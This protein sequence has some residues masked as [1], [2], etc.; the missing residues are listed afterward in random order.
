MRTYPVVPRSALFLCL[1]VLVAIPLVDARAQTA[2]YTPYEGQPGKDV[3]WLPTQQTLVDIMLD[4][5]KVTPQD[6]VIDLG[7]GDGRTVIAAAKRGVRALGIEYNP[8]LVELSRRNAAKEGVGDNASFVVG[9]I[10]ETDYSQG[11]VITMFLLP[12]LN[13]K[14]RPH[15]LTLTPGTR[16]VSNT[17]TMGDWEPD[18]TAEMPASANCSNHCTALLWVVPAKVEG[19]WQ[20]VQGRLRL[21]Q[22]YQMI[23]GTLDNG[24]KSMPI[25]NG[26]IRGKDIHFTVGD[27]RYAGRVG[28]NLMQGTFASGNNTGTWGATRIR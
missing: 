7:S 15:L 2:P 16:V 4:L 9:D 13:L 28:G 10:F 27:V 19:E 14:L 26:R 21:L 5:A 8:D 11:T 22:T 12:A 23:S 17:F 1:I 20:L 3:I 6:Y 25:A 24:G 18:A